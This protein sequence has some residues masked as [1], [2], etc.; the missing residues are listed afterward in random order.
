MKIDVSF[1]DIIYAPVK[2]VKW[3]FWKGW[4]ITLD[5]FHSSQQIVRRIHNIFFKKVDDNKLI[6]GNYTEFCPQLSPTITE[7]FYINLPSECIYEVSPDS[8]Y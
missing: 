4:K 7:S 1:Y 2:A 8:P 5:F 3:V 6:N